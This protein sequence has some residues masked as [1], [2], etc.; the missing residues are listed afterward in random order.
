MKA[1]SFTANFSKKS[2][3]ILVFLSLIFMT[4][5]FTSSKCRRK[6][7]WAANY[8]RQANKPKEPC[9]RLW[10]PFWIIFFFF[11]KKIS[12]ANYPWKIQYYSWGK[13]P[14]RSAVLI[15]MKGS[16]F[17]S[18]LVLIIRKAPTALNGRKQLRGLP[19]ALKFREKCSLLRL[20]P[21]WQERQG[22][23][24]QPKYNPTP[25]SPGWAEGCLT[26]T[27]LSS[28]EL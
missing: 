27:L 2:S 8:S 17:F 6:V 25:P 1:R 15:W 26:G 7:T 13:N 18:S 19:L 24:R 14:H 28:N 11:N 3:W 16:A 10:K 4:I 5:G 23:M 21:R 20:K 22:T 12:R 9:V